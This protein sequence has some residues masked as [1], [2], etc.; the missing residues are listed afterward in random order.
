MSTQSDIESR[1]LLAYNQKFRCE[2]CGGR[3]ARCNYYAHR[4]T[5]THKAA[6]ESKGIS[7]ASIKAFTTPI[8]KEEVTSKKQRMNQMYPDRITCALCNGNYMWYSKKQHENTK[9]HTSAM[10]ADESS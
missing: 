10:V 6:L 8:T 7:D 1:L 2:A 5:K 9:K 3:F 4:M